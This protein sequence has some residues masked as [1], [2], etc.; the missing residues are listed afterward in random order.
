VKNDGK[1]LFLNKNTFL[2]STCLRKVTSCTDDSLITSGL[3]EHPDNGIPG[4]FFTFFFFSLINLKST[5][6]YFSSYLLSCLF[7]INLDGGCVFLRTSSSSSG[8]GEGTC[9][10][11]VWFVSFLFFIFHSFFTLFYTCTP[12][13]NNNRNDNIY[14]LFFIFRMR[15]VKS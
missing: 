9:Q 7:F 8:D 14:F 12:D 6:S 11:K 2:V 5:C 10:P 4:V 1:T 3:C 13:N 15:N